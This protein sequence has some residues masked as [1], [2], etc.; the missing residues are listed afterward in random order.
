[1]KFNLDP[2]HNNVGVSE[3]KLELNPIEDVIAEIKL[4]QLNENYQDCCQSEE[5]NL[6]VDRVKELGGFVVNNI[7][8][9]PD[10]I[11]D[12]ESFTKSLKVMDIVTVN[13]T[14][15]CCYTKK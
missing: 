6:L 12:N 8:N 7:G 2:M 11:L 13:S 3:N 15:S 5:A 4:T 10:L 9:N 14:R 1:M